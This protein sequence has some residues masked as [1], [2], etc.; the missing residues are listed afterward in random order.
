MIACRFMRVNFKGK[1]LLYAGIL[2]G[3]CFKACTHDPLVGPELPPADTTDT[4]GGQGNI[5]P[6]DP[7][8]VYFESQVL[9]FLIANCAKSGCHD[10]NTAEDGVILTSYERVTQTAD[11]RPFEPEESDLYE[12][13]TEEDPDKRM[14]PPPNTSLTE[15]QVSLVYRW[16]L[17]GAQDLQC[18]ETSCDTT[19]LSFTQT[20]QPIFQR[21][22]TGCH[23]AAVVNAGIRLHDYEHVVQ[24][25]QSGRLLGAIR[26]DAGYSPMPQ[27]GNKLPAC[28][29]DQIAAWI[30]A[31]TPNN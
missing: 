27:G 13:L 20:I 19:E 16:I 15:A 5:P 1:Q 7:D 14:P 10:A 29:I 26:H 18:Q 22:C 21:S 9:P 23:G 28:E 3:L 6:C 31:G 30:E 17:Q 2:L 4:D 25:V 24:A 12:V 11:V 8:S